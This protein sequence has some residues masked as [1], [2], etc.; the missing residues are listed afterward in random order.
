MELI[1]NSLNPNRFLKAFFSGIYDGAILHMTEKWY[2]AVLEQ[3]EEGSIILD[4]GVGTASAL[5][6]CKDIVISKKLRIIGIDYDKYYITAGQDSIQNEGPVLSKLIQLHHCDLYNREQLDSLLKD[7]NV[8]T[9]YFSGSFSLIPKPVEALK[10]AAL[11]L[12]KRNTTI[13][14]NNGSST[15]HAIKRD[16]D[17]GNI[18]ITQ[19]Y[20]RRVLPLF[21]VIKPLL[22]YLTTIDFGN[23]VRE[24]EVLEF[25]EDN[26][27]KDLL[28]L[29]DHRVL[30]GSVDNY[31]QAAYIS[32]LR[33]R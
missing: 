21:S 15:E 9:V 7:V 22:K 3:Q 19:T 26:D 20:Q 31:W 8:N 11:I 6:R 28:E 25:F 5:L 23:L 27:V 10:V 32:I 2:K 17:L 4:V 29:K 24:E 30:D 13:D 33:M 1:K 12:K 18:Y 16:E 14:G